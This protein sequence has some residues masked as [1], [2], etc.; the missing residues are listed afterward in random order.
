[1]AAGI[2]RQDAQAH[3]QR[4]QEKYSLSGHDELADLI[5]N[6]LNILANELYDVS[7][8]F[9]QELLQNADDNDYACE[10][11]TIKFTYK[12]GFLRVDCNEVGF[13]PA[14]VD[15]ICAI[16]KSTKI[17]TD[18]SA[19]Y[20]GEKGIG[21]KSV[22]RIADVVWIST[23]NY[24][25]KFDKSRRFGM[26]SPEWAEFPQQHDGSCTSFLLQLSSD[27]DQD[28]LVD[29]LTKFDPVQLIFLRQLRHVDIEL[30]Y[31]DGQVLTSGIHRTDQ[32]IG[33][34]VM[35]MLEFGKSRRHYLVWSHKVFPMPPEA[36]RPVKGLTQ[37]ASDLVLAFP[38]G[39]E[40]TELR[41]EEH[42]VYAGL[43]IGHLPGITFLIQGDFLLAA[44]RLHIDTS[45]QWN[46][47]LRDG[48][49]D[50][51]VGAIEYLK[52]TRL[53]Y[54]WPLFVPFQNEDTGFFKSAFKA[55]LVRLKKM[56][57]LE[58]RKGSICKPSRL[59]L[60]DRED[61]LDIGGVPFT[62]NPQNAHHYLSD[63]YT[64]DSFEAMK[65]LG[66]K[67]LCE[68]VALKHFKAMVTHDP[69]TFN[70]CPPEWHESIAKALSLLARDPQLQKELTKLPIIP[71]VGGNW[72]T[73]LDRPR[74]FMISE[75]MKLE[76]LPITD[77]V[78][79]VDPIASASQGRC[80]L[81]RLL[82]VR[83]LEGSELFDYIC[84]RH[85]S[86]FFRP[87]EWSVSQLIA[88]AKLLYMTSWAPSTDRKID[89]WLASAC[90]GRYKGSELYLHKVSGQNTPQ[91]RLAHLLKTHSFPE[92]HPD[93][94]RQYSDP[95][96]S[97]PGFER[98]LTSQLQV[99]TC[100]RLVSGQQVS[101]E[102]RCALTHNAADLIN[103]LLTKWRLYSQLLEK[104]LLQ[105]ESAELI[106]LREK[107]IMAI[108]EAQVSTPMGLRRVDQTFLGV[109]DELLEPDLIPK[110][111]LDRKVTQ[112]T[113]YRLSLLGVTVKPAVTLYLSALN[114]L[115]KQHRPSRNA[116]S[117]IY[118]QIQNKYE[119]DDKMNVKQ[120]E[121]EWQWMSISDCA[122][123]NTNLESIYPR[124]KYL[125]RRLL[126]N[127][128]SPLHELIAKIVKCG[129][130]ATTHRDVAEY[131]DKLDDILSLMS[132]RQAVRSVK[133]LMSKAVFPVLE[134]N[135]TK[136][137]RPKMVSVKDSNWFIADR[138]QLRKSF[139]GKVPLLDLNPDQIELVP[140]LLETFNLNSRKL[141][142]LVKSDMRPRG[143][144]EFDVSL[145]M[146]F[147]DRYN[148]IF[149]LIPPQNWGSLSKQMKEVTVINVVEIS[150]NF[151]LKN[152][153]DEVRGRSVKSLA[154]SSA[155]GNNL[156]IFIAGGQFPIPEIVQLISN[157]CGIEEP[158]H[159]CLLYT[160]FSQPNQERI[161]EAFSKAGY[162]THFEIDS[163]RI[164][165]AARYW[166][167]TG[168][169]ITVPSPYDYDSFSDSDSSIDSNGQ[170]PRFGVKYKPSRERHK[171]YKKKRTRD[172]RLP[173]MRYVG[174]PDYTHVV[175]SLH[176]ETL[177]CLGQLLL[178]RYFERNLGEAYSPD[179]HW[180]SSLRTRSGFDSFKATEGVEDHSPFTFRDVGISRV[181]SDFMVKNNVSAARRWRN[182]TPSFHFELAISVGGTSEP[183]LWTSK[184]LDR[185]RQVYSRTIEADDEPSDVLIM[186]RISNIYTHPTYQF[187]L[188]PW[189]MIWSEHMR[190]MQGTVFEA[191]IQVHGN[192]TSNLQKQLI[193]NSACSSTQNPELAS[194]ALA[195][196]HQMKYTVRKELQDFQGATSYTSRIE[197]SHGFRSIPMTDIS[198]EDQAPYAYRELESGHIRL[199][200][201]FPGE[202]A[203]EIR[204]MILVMPFQEAIS[205]YAVSYVWGDPEQRRF[206]IYTPDGVLRVQKSIHQVLKRLRNPSESVILW[207]DAIC[208]N[209]QNNQ[210]KANQLQ[211]L[212]RI[213]QNSESTL[214]VIGQDIE[215]ES[216]I[217]KL[218]EFS[219]RRKASR[220]ITQDSREEPPN[221]FSLWEDCDLQQNDEY[222]SIMRHVSTIFSHPWFER[223]WI[224]QEAVASARVTLICGKYAVDWGDLYEATL[225]L[226]RQM[227]WLEADSPPSW[228]SFHTLSELR[229]WESR[230]QRWSILLLLET[231]RKVKSTLARDRFFSL[232]GIACDGNL[233]GFEPDYDVPLECV[234]RKFARCLVTQGM[235]MMLLYRAGL[236]TQLNRFPSW[237]PDWTK[238][239]APSLSTSLSRGTVFN[240][241]G[242][243]ETDIKCPCDDEA[244]SDE[245]RAAGYLVDRIQCISKSRNVQSQFKAYFDEIDEMT[246]SPELRYS[247]PIAG[248]KHAQ[249]AVAEAL[250]LKESYKAFR[251]ICKKQKWTN[252]YNSSSSKTSPQIGSSN[253]E[254]GLVTKSKSYLSLLGG[255]IEGWRF[256]TTEAGRCG[257]TIPD[258][259]VG[260]IIV[261]VA[262]GEVPFVLR[263]SQEREGLY[264][265]LG[266]C[267]VSDIMYGEVFE[268]GQP[269]KELFT[270]Y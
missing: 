127:H 145:T 7:T 218:T 212:P 259:K 261:I 139:L 47:A 179:K 138:P 77:A 87:E 208:I 52:T 225:N 111:P 256:M 65:A 129:K 53:K 167:K 198:W 245:L 231:F 156:Q 73:A 61:F 164:N 241:C 109:M 43:P 136:A 183:F 40:S 84:R 171:I 119:D 213:F 260:D 3:I 102:L 93:Y 128:E 266:E 67:S 270:I 94:Y 74:P 229:V 199:F 161:E 141:S 195:Q 185:S 81:F 174:R 143:W 37:R 30:I 29:V 253:E 123:Q 57:L 36:K 153:D 182:K 85:S 2:S 248:A 32:R 105:E 216:A 135:G 25:F 49:A 5:D 201:L 126:T 209:Q 203:D 133:P 66:V 246:T 24:I 15:A 263:K 150:E 68:K 131:F 236:S 264:R 31:P 118:E 38:I 100:L 33:D 157:H 60:V 194:S 168:G 110:F 112:G 71:I 238:P 148:F 166:G 186:V 252:K 16:R 54:L 72:V 180:T 99:S 184:Q 255:T 147:R 233:D 249:V 10:A 267:Y 202:K 244:T 251:K 86:P 197:P 265:L 165:P 35:T 222:E 230:G 242:N 95:R 28:E 176:D 170:G 224:V 14:N 116:I 12:H 98:F 44:S 55:T 188:D 39:D 56:E 89:L 192:G 204:G 137:C 196:T 247:A 48:L 34:G 154:M 19:C 88:H 189:K 21:F 191:V 227:T 64:P 140:S 76:D 4:I 130:S 125:F 90:G 75:R 101:P 193:N 121:S 257:I 144:L 51:F 69:G 219:K 258:T 122:K 169:L 240:A 132:T 160:L 178:S 262:G 1:M 106:E 70:S 42:N 41:L 159:L 59:F 142:E 200:C 210:E 269:E 58:S 254:M 18:T 45:R 97:G 6:S 207:A 107:I 146:F 228:L 235:G 187:F 151:M 250:D 46:R 114:S 221:Y 63:Q 104:D 9:I 163:M 155:A 8:H 214:A 158:S 134:P 108:G 234:V 243:T 115:Q 175:E 172:R 223:A 26:V 91:A 23:G 232:L 217:E 239:K 124:S 120:E 268:T 103:M 181:A 17:G 78:P 190:I 27:C 83:Q 62:D 11:P 80:E 22:F 237:I 82:G 13:T 50:A 215:N 173:I 152:G 96:G 211:L 206:K 20:T 162:D 92:I 177:E 205:Y 220:K 226:S 117:H 149:D 113:L 79:T